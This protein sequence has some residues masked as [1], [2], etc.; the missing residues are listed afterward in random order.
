MRTTLVKI[1]V[2]EMSAAT[3]FGIAIGIANKAGVKPL[4]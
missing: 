2:K 4:V 3:Q 1:D